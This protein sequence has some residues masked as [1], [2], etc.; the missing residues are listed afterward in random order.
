LPIG[1]LDGGHI[2][3]A[4]F[5]NGYNVFARRLHKLMPLVAVGVFGWVYHLVRVEMGGRW[6]RGFSLSAGIGAGAPWLMW[7]ALV[8]IL[9]RLGGGANHPPVDAKPLPASRK[10]LFWF[11]VVAFAA[12]FMPVPFRETRTG[13]EPAP[14]DDAS[15]ALP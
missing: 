4:Y 7:F 14:A 6:Q 3:T 5:G 8:A 9:R 10:L 15:A 11:V 2:A 13:A 12:I 1:Q